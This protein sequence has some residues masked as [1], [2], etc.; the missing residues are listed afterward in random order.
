M[1][2]LETIRRKIESAKDLHSV[3]K[4]MKALAAVNIHTYEKAVRAINFYFQNIEAAFQVVLKETPDIFKTVSA[5]EDYPVGIIVFG[6]QRG[7]AGNFNLP[8]ANKLDT[9]QKN[10]GLKDK[11]PP[12]VCIVGDRIS[13]QLKD[14][15]IVADYYLD[16]PSF[17][18]HLDGTIQEILLIIEEWR[19]QKKA[20]SIHLF[21]NRPTSGSSFTPNHSQLYPLNH[22][23]LQELSTRKWD[24]RSIPMHTIP[25]GDLFNQIIQQYLYISLYKAFI[26]TMASENASRLIAMR[27][28]EQNI[29]EK[30]EDLDSQFNKQRQD[31]IT[32][33]LLDIVAGFEALTKE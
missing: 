25:A 10:I 13:E 1:Q 7:M 17:R 12:V 16:F 33:E 26:E 22:E 5:E 15:G 8:I 29:E 28:A 24:S 27:K 11:V 32:E 4:T 2:M 6:A 30:L 31:S 9:W 23:W 3:V 20:S 19:F 18:Y 14:L 21:Y